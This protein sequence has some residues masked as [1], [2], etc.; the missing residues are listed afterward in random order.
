[1]SPLA[2]RRGNVS[3]PGVVKRQTHD[4]PWSVG[5]EVVSSEVRQGGQKLSG[6]PRCLFLFGFR[7]G[8][9]RLSVMMVLHPLFPLRLHGIKF[10]L[11]VCIQEFTN[12]IVRRFVNVHHF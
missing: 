9:G 10:L 5:R 11:L 8:A 7:W 1:M 2:Q 12:L 6:P 4:D 3:L